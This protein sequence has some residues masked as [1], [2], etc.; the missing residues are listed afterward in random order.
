MKRGGESVTMASYG[1]G[2]DVQYDRLSEFVKLEMNMRTELLEEWFL[3][4]DSMFNT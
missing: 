2:K 1:V 3:K 4:L